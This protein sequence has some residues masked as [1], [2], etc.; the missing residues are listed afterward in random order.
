[1][2]TPACHLWESCC[3]KTFTARKSQRDILAQAASHAWQAGRAPLQQGS[4]RAAPRAARGQVRC[5]PGQD[6]RPSPLLAQGPCRC[7]VGQ[8]GARCRSLRSTASPKLTDTQRP[9]LHSP[10]HRSLQLPA[11]LSHCGTRLPPPR[12]GPQSPE[13]SQASPSLSCHP[14]AS[15][16]AGTQILQGVR[17]LHAFFVSPASFNLRTL[18]SKTRPTGVPQQR[19]LHSQPWVRG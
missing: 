10:A 7:S 17:Y 14:S 5:A 16:A 9:G 3:R 1:M 13:W 19:A 6:T 8:P 2:L 11:H 18:P 12:P 4:Q 15:S